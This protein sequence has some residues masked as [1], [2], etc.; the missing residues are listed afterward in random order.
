MAQSKRRKPR[1]V[2]AER[3]PEP[4]AEMTDKQKR[5]LHDMYRTVR[6]IV[7]KRTEK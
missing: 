4:L 7:R 2:D 3:T 5:Q 6:K 1:K